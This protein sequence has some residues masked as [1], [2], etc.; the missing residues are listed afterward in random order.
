MRF[1]ILN[2]QI[3]RGLNISSEINKIPLENLVLE[4]SKCGNKYNL[5]D[6]SKE[7]DFTSIFQFEYEYFCKNCKGNNFNIQFEFIPGDY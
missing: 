1:K 5:K 6:I 4:C 2:L 7:L 3:E